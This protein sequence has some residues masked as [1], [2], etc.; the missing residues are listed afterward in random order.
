MRS[1]YAW[2]LL[3]KINLKACNVNNDEYFWPMIMV[4]LSVFLRTKCVCVRTVYKYI[5]FCSAGA[6]SISYDG[7]INGTSHWILDEKSSG[8]GH[9]KAT[10]GIW[11]A[12]H[13]FAQTYSSTSPREM[14]TQKPKNKAFIRWNKLIKTVP[15]YIYIFCW[16]YTIY[17]YT[18]NHQMMYSK[19]LWK[20]IDNNKTTQTKWK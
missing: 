17:I 11:E 4:F 16:I 19:T 12:I 9:D 13:E 20:E 5:F 1:L 18:Q 10:I 7:Q 8:H 2:L 6:F 15:I 3:M 14:E